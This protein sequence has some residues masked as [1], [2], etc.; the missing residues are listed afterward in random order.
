MWNLC[1]RLLILLLYY[2]NSP[3]LYCPIFDPEQRTNVQKWLQIALKFS[4]FNR[5]LINFSGQVLS[6]LLFYFIIAIKLPFSRDHRCKLIWSCLE[7]RRITIILR[8][9][10][11]KIYEYMVHWRF[12]IYHSSNKRNDEN[13]CS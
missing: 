6:F 3:F 12:F 10:L 11:A 8:L 7:L 9:R 2:G 4:R 5:N 13:H 1:K